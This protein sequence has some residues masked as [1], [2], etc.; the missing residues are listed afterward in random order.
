MPGQSYTYRFQSVTQL[1]SSGYWTAV[2]S[3]APPPVPDSHADWQVLGNSPPLTMRS[4]DVLFTWGHSSTSTTSTDL[5][6]V[7]RSSDNVTWYSIGTAMPFNG[8]WNDHEFIDPNANVGQTY[9]YKVRAHNVFGYSGFS[10][11]VDITTTLGPD[12]PT[13]LSAIQVSSEVG[14][15]IWADLGDVHLT[16]DASDGHGFPIDSYVVYYTEDLNDWYDGHESWV[17]NGNPVVPEIFSG[18]HDTETIIYFKV[19]AYTQVGE[20]YFSDVLS[21]TTLPAPDAPTNFAIIHVSEGLQIIW[22]EPNGNGFP[23]IHYEIFRS[24][25]GADWHQMSHISTNT[26]FI[27]TS[28]NAGQSYRYMVKAYSVG[29]GGDYSDWTPSVAFDN[30]VPVAPTNLTV[31]QSMGTPLLTWNIYNYPSGVAFTLPPGYPYIDSFDVL[32]SSDNVTWSSVSSVAA[33]SY[34]DVTFIDPNA[35]VGQTYYYKVRAHNVFGFSDPSDIVSF[36][37]VSTPDA[38]TNLSVTNSYPTTNPYLT[39]NTPFENGGTI[40]FYNV[41]RSED[42]ISWSNVQTTTGFETTYEDP[43]VNAGQTYYYKVR[44]HNVFGFSDPSDIVSFTVVSTPDAPTNLSVTNSY[45][46]TNPYLTWNTPFENGGTIDFYNVYRSEDN[47]SWSN[48]QTTT[49]FETTYEDPNVNAGQTY[50]YKV[51]AHNVSGLGNFSD[52]VS[53]TVVSTPDAPAN[54]VTALDTSS[55]G[56]STVILIWDEPNDNCF[57]TPGCYINYYDISRSEDGMSWPFVQVIYSASGCV[58]AFSCPTEFVPNPNFQ[59]MFVDQSVNIGQTYYYNIRAHNTVG[60]SVY[61]DTVSISVEP[62]PDA[63]TITSITYAPN[64]LHLRWDEPNDYGT[65]ISSYLI[66]RSVDNISWNLLTQL[67][68]ASN[69]EFTDTTVNA[70]QTYYYKVRSDNIFG[71]SAYSDTVSLPAIFSPDAPIILSVHDNSISQ[72]LLSLS[73]YHPNPINVDEYRIERSNDNVTWQLV[74]V[75]SQIDD[76]FI[77]N[78]VLSGQVYY[79]RIQAYNMAGFSDYSNIF[80]GIPN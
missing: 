25:Q 64:G 10:D 6:E 9:Y 65:P 44:A 7:W 23:I 69:T 19:K 57:G 73:W 22:D 66:H 34:S 14:I 12:T 60:Y 41:Y 75:E 62:V 27:D 18:G 8:A 58:T 16:W 79:Y 43:N 1:G 35:N 32:R 31:T 55:S 52:I 47:I 71:L 50:Y 17:D 40:D 56:G 42:N 70:G 59:S 72:T 45:P 63:P 51:R 61:S 15:P 4:D 11:V 21:I 67:S 29:G 78:N 74:A 5:F 3:T 76:R 24:P 46:T 48:V 13:N 33:S 2:I 80:S 26:A 49:G 20:S 39:W 68:G 53:F 54:L 77:D 30:S 36:T 28:V 37:V 38:P